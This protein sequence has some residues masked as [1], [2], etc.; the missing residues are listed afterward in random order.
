[1]HIHQRQQC[2]SSVP[3]VYQQHTSSVPAVY[4]QC[5]SSIPAVYQQCTSSVPAV[6]QQCT[7]S[8]P[9]VYQQCTSCV[10]AVYQQCTNSVPTVYLQCTSS[11]PAVCQHVPE[12]LWL[13]HYKYRQFIYSKRPDQRYVRQYSC[14]L[15]THIT[16][17]YYSCKATI[18]SYSR[19]IYSCDYYI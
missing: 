13:P 3:A 4:H 16:A 12:H 9:A 2:T 8:V 10:P 17:V 18:S 15:Q 6:Y 1:M 14:T 11:V 7:N 19:H 5:T